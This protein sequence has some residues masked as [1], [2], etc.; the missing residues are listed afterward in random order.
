[1]HADYS[2]YPDASVLFY[3]ERNFIASGMGA[4]FL[5]ILPHFL[6]EHLQ[7]VGGKPDV[8]YQNL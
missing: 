5:H 8:S 3:K 6:A 2:G 1:M 7:T 4:Y